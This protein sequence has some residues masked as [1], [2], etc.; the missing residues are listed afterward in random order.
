M[1]RLGGDLE[2]DVATLTKSKINDISIFTKGY[3]F[4]IWTDFGRSALQIAIEDIL[5]RGGKREVYL[6]SFICPS[7]KQAFRF[8]QFTIHYYNQDLLTMNVF[9]MP[10][11]LSGC[12]FLYVH[13]FGHM[14]ESVMSW[15][16]EKRKEQSFYII[17]DR[18]Q[19][20][21]SIIPVKHFVNYTI[22]S[23]RKY[24]EVPDGAL[25]VSNNPFKVKRKLQGINSEFLYKQ[26]KGKILRQ[27]VSDG[28]YYLS[29]LKQS[30]GSL[31]YYLHAHNISDISRFLLERIDIREVVMKRRMNWILLKSL[32]EKSQFTKKYI[33]PLFTTLRVE[34][35]PLGFVIYTD[36]RNELRAFLMEN[37]IFCPIHWSLD[38]YVWKSDEFLENRILTLIIDQRM[39][40]ED[41]YIL[42]NKLEEYYGGIV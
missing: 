30:E 3:D 29:D 40:S 4:Y 35:V 21:F 22:Y 27:L 9:N 31:D 2:I 24:V 19:A 41:I 1:K 7:V 37:N 39:S 18:V 10:N 33:K 36:Y 32:I 17:E 12:T 42:F 16:E 13:Y 26:L 6:P 25:V 5:A 20:A 28:H 23:F 38:E 15:C 11:D 34:E 14:N 8:F